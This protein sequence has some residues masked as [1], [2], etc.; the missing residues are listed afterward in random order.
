MEIH[1][2]AALEAIRLFKLKKTEYFF[3]SFSQK[4]AQLNLTQLTSLV[5][6]VS[7]T[8]SFPHCHKFEMSKQYSDKITQIK[9]QYESLS[10]LLLFLD[11]MCLS[12]WNASR[13]LLL[14]LNELKNKLSLEYF[15]L[16]VNFKT[17]ATNQKLQ[18]FI[19]NA[20]NSLKGFT[21]SND[22]IQDNLNIFYFN[23]VEY[24]V[25]NDRNE[26][27]DDETIDLILNSI[28]EKELRSNNEQQQPFRIEPTYRALLIQIVFKNYNEKVI[29]HLDKWFKQGTITGQNQLFESSNELALLFQDCVHDQYIHNLTAKQQTL[30]DQITLAN[31]VCAELLVASNQRT[32]LI[33]IFKSRKMYHATYDVACLVVLAKLKFCLGTMSRACYSKDVFDAYKHQKE[34][35]EFNTNLKN[36][37]TIT[38]GQGEEAHT[39]G[40]T[41]TFINYLIKDMIRKY[42]SSSIKYV[43]AE[44]DLSWMTPPSIIGNQEVNKQ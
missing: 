13:D 40:Q 17:K 8:L 31:S 24:L 9:Q 41:D 27:P 1:L 34:F 39:K 3:D 10:L 6:L 28:T 37:I 23:T 15:N 42:G 30:C 11:T 33:Q 12:D 14:R 38:F 32:N 22:E 4:K 36:L 16:N 7:Q 29:E 2:D 18:M 19:V 26:P 20:Y 44:S 25:F 5:Q 43:L 35:K 21:K